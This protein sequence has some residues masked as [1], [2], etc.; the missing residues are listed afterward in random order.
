[1]GDSSKKFGFADVGLTLIQL[2][3]TDRKKKNIYIYIYF[4]FFF[5]GARLLKK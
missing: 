5:L 1:M 2:C 3:G 4:F